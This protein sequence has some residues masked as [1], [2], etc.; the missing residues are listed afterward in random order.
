MSDM[1]DDKFLIHK[2]PECGA[3][4]SLHDKNC[5]YGED[6]LPSYGKSSAGGAI[7]G[8]IC[9]LVLLT[10]VC[11]L[12]NIDIDKIPTFFAGLLYIFGISAGVALV[13]FIISLFG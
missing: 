7:I 8:V 4:G 3:P 10:L 9:G 2:C 11:V 13:Q 12:F 6:P 1:S 5:S